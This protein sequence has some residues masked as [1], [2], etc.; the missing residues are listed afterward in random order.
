MSQN[1]K[2]LFAPL[3]A[4]GHIYASIGI[5][6]QLLSRGHTVVFVTPNSFKGKLK[7]LG[8][9]EEYIQEP[10]EGVS[11]EEWIERINLVRPLLALTPLGILE[12]FFVPY[13]K[14]M[15]EDTKNNDFK[16]RKIMDNVK[17]DVVVVDIFMQN[18][19]LVDQ[20]K[21]SNKKLI[22]FN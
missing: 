5:A 19:A 16:L 12:H 3:D 17:P 4:A 20:G 14:W 10:H 22:I 21:H 7:P 6:Q 11:K 13:Y 9:A 1:L 18:P 15:V 8:I 2:F